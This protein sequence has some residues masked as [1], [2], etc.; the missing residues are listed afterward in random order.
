MGAA[1]GDIA[2]GSGDIR[3]AA[4]FVEG[5]A[6]AADLGKDGDS[7]VASFASQL[8]GR[9]GAESAQARSAYDDAAARRDDATIRRDNF[10]GVNIDEELA[11]MVV[12]QN[13]YSAS[14]RV[15]T[16]ASD[17]YDTLLAMLA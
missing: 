10:A 15:I 3:G 6:T 17:M 9:A 2:V 16:T 4:D 13:S 7:L 11:N 14:A 1:V 12:L 8:L 5:L